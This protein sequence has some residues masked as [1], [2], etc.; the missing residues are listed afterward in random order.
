MTLKRIIPSAVLAVGVTAGIGLF[1][2]NMIATE[3]TPQEKG[4]VGT[5]QINPVEADIE[6]SIDRKP[7]E[8]L[9]RVETPPPPP[10]I[11]HG[12]TEK[13]TEA[14]VIIDGEFDVF[15]PVTIKIAGPMMVIADRNPQPILRFPPVMPSNA[16]RSG[17]CNVT[18]DVS[19]AG[20]PMNVS[21]SYCT[22]RLF[23]SATLKSVQK[24]K[25]NPRI[26]DGRAVAM[27]GLSNRVRFKL[28][29]ERGNLIPE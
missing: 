18:F 6:I 2:A 25:F 1:M 28:M 23:R 16:Q 4:A 13:P 9:E 19:A 14:P 26:Q 12:A 7:P 15:D 27:E 5:F 11:D 8:L 17:H 3:F 10:M 20:L 24:W 29:D 22:E 21:A